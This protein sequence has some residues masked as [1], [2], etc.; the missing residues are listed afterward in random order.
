MKSIKP[1]KYHFKVVANSD[2]FA[3]YD[4]SKHSLII[5][6]RHYSERVTFDSIDKA[7]LGMLNKMCELINAGFTSIELC[8]INPFVN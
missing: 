4:E 8:E 5:S 7:R 6:C 3:S 2:E 1:T